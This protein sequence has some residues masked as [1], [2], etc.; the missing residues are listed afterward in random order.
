VYGQPEDFAPLETNKKTAGIPLLDK[1]VA[2]QLPAC[3]LRLATTDN[4]SAWQHSRRQLEP[5]HMCSA[6]LGAAHAYSK[7]S[8]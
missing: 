7:P 4:T 2:I 1:A 8:T 6:G 5:K 3:N